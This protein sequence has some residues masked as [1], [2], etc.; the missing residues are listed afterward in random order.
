MIFPVRCFSCGSLIGNKIRLYQ[1]KVKEKKNK[2]P[3][4]SQY[5]DILD[6]LNIKRYCCRSIYISYKPM[7][8][9]ISNPYLTKKEFI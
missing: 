3:N 6:T 4:C 2:N 5:G 8:K 1:K 9:L 7:T